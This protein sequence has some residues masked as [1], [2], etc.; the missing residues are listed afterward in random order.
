VVKRYAVIPT[1]SRPGDLADSVKAINTQVDRVFIVDNLSD[2]PVRGLDHPANTR[3]ICHPDD[4]PNLSALWNVG[5]DLAASYADGEPYDVAV[6]NDDCIVPEGWLEAVAGPMRELGAAAGSSDQFGQLGEPLVHRRPGPVDL[7]WRLCGYAFVLRGET[8]LRADEELAW[9]YG[10]DA[11]DWSARRLGG[12]VIVPFFPVEHR[13]PNGSTVGALAEQAGRD[14][15][16][17][18]AKWGMTPW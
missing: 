16:T 3:V 10:D 14:R 15:A 1:R 9:W 13:H 11:L 12:T 7:R 17:F 6:L 2:P 4:P 18:I 5:L 8:G